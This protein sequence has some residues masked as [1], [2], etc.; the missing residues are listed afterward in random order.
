MMGCIFVMCPCCEL[1]E[2]K[3]GGAV[4]G[5]GT[6]DLRNWASELEILKHS[7]QPNYKSLQAC[8]FSVRICPPHIYY[9]E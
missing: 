3:E 1:E 9:I 5:Q 2:D 6:D 8:A 4:A 7:T